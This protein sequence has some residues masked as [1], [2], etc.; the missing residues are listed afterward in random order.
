MGIF[1]IFEK[2]EWEY[3]DQNI[4]SAT[5]KNISI[6]LNCDILT[7]Q[8][9]STQDKGKVPIEI[10]KSPTLKNY[11]MSDITKKLSKINQNK[12]KIENI[13]LY[14]SA[15]DT[16]CEVPYMLHL[17]STIDYKNHPIYHST[18]FHKIQKYLFDD[19]D[20]IFIPIK[21]I[22]DTYNKFCAPGSKIGSFDKMTKNIGY[23]DPHF[24]LESL[25]GLPIQDIDKNLST[26][27]RLEIMSK[28]E[29]IFEKY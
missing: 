17:H 11:T 5:H 24:L 18:I 26:H 21:F 15:Y 3:S 1:E 7:M 27:K 20:E 12:E 16:T 19:G 23:Y 9:S 28:M 6:F 25:M 22:N 10:L 2:N 13:Y 8:I 29:K 4:Q 14:L